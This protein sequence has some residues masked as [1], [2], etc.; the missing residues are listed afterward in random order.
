MD[1]A[2]RGCHD[3]GVCEEGGC[4]GWPRWKVYKYIK[5]R[6]FTKNA[7]CQSWNREKTEKEKETKQRKNEKK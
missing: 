7:L 4:R 5:V 2:E 1:W 6:W 3:G